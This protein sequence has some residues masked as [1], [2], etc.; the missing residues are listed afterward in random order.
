[1]STN[2]PLA[3]LRFLILLTLTTAAAALAHAQSSGA[4]QD[5]LSALRWRFI[6]PNGNRVAAVAGAAGDPLVAYAGAAS[7]GI[8]KTENGGTSWRPVFDREHVSAIGA[9]AV[10]ES[11]PNVVWAGTGETFLIRPFYPMGDGVYR[12]TD[13]GEHWQHV[14]LEQTGHI[15]RIVIDPHDAQRVF[16][17]ALGQLFKPQPERGIYRTTDGGATWQQVLKVDDNTGCSD[18]A[19]DPS[20]PNTLFAGMWPLQIHPWAIDSGGASGGIYATHDGGATWHKL[21]GNG[22]PAA[23]HPVGKVAVAIAPSNP[24]RVYALVQDTQPSFY[25]SDD[26]GGTWTLVSHSHL[27]LQRDSYYDR[28][29]VSTSNPDLLFFLSPYFVVSTDAAKTFIRPGGRGGGPAGAF[30]SA[31]GDNHDMWIDPLNPKRLMVGNDAGVSI[32]LDGGRSY[33]AI[34]LPIA[35]VY[36]V[37]TDDEIPYNVYGN[38]QDS[39]SFRGPSNTLGGGIRAADFQSVGGCESGFATPEPG[40]PDIVWSGCYEGVVSRMNLRDGQSRDVSV[41]PDVADGWK[42]ADVKYRWHWTIPLAISHFDPKRVYVGSQYV[43]ETADGGQ[44]WKV[45]SPDLTL[46]DKSHEGNSGG[47]TYDNLYTYDAAVIYSIAESPIKRGVIWAGTNDGQ[48]NVTSDGGA[49][50]TNLTKN[51][52][53]LPPMGTIW[54]IEASPFDAATAY[55]TVNLEQMGDYNAY[56]YKTADGGKSWQMISAGIP[57]GFN[58][59]AHCVIEDPVRKGMLY[60]GTDNAVYVS[61]DDGGRWTSL[62]NNLPP[63]PVYWLTVQQ[64]FNDLVISTYGRGDFI[65]DDIT[66]LRDLD[67]AQQANGPYLF[68]LRPAYRFRSVTS[69]PMAEPNPR[70]VGQNPQY[71]AV[72]NFYLPQPADKV[73]LTVLGSDGAAIRTMTMPG[74]AGLNRAWWD[75]RGEDGKMP[76]MLVP[77]PDAPW[78]ENGPEGYH[79][80]TGIMI[81]DVVRGPLMVPGTYTVRLT[82][83]DRMLTAPLTVLADPHSAGTAASMAS[84]LRFRNEMIKEIGNVSDMIERLER[85]R[86]Q[87]ATL[88]EKYGQDPSQK[89]V[90]DAARKLA[91]RVMSVET[92]LIDIYLTNGNEDLNRHP[93]QLY[94]KMTALYDKSQAD[95][96]PTASE[97]AVNDSL[98]AWMEKSE[99][100]LRLLMNED[101]SGFNEV[102]KAHHLPI[103]QQ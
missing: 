54:N 27:M 81:P 49:H 63:A 10:S 41:W 16:V 25:R 8:W 92:E 84:E 90:I 69:A 102:L 28:F 14:G 100:Q 35:Q 62:S 103:I 58:S 72:I 36:H 33:Q 88:E 15:G 56:V 44:T 22:L 31:G 37:T 9:L 2:P 83:G 13:A 96:G 12:S 11:S 20:D 4:P 75:L 66:A 1:M 101:V 86:K 7:G 85:L 34:R 73:T 67:K 24:K 89:A 76:H 5:P 98:R 64:R 50:W 42:P 29:G 59:S 26:G 60:L 30:A 57:H 53:D 51:I 78:L 97:E 43:H 21:A 19:I 18:L 23:D 45:I 48:V 71:G 55:I 3:R 95:L 79:I 74:R 40:N 6:G 80:L 46:N 82:A 17:C 65:L 47:I 39:S 68:P 61:W 77:P 94:Q 87:L 93:S 99:G 32:S 70:I 38:I 91:D 52:P